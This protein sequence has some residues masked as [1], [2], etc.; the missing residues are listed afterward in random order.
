MSSEVFAKPLLRAFL[1]GLGGCSGKASE[2][3]THQSCLPGIWRFKVHAFGCFRMLWGN[4]GVG[5]FRSLMFASHGRDPPESATA[6]VFVCLVRA[7]ILRN[8]VR[9]CSLW[10]A[11]GSCMPRSRNSALPIARKNRPPQRGGLRAPGPYQVVAGQRF[12]QCFRPALQ[13]NHA[14]LEGP[15]HCPD[16]P[17]PG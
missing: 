11:P 5:W 3:P 2:F 13:D 17:S 7:A 1:A 12:F 6:P 9:D 14:D 15:R 8:L 4:G 10:F 16:V